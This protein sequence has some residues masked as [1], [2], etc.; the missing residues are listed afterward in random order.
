MNVESGTEAAQFPENTLMGFSLQ[1]ILLKRTV[2]G[3]YAFAVFNLGSPVHVP[4]GTGPLI[5]IRIE[6]CSQI[7]SSLLG[8]KVDYYIGLLYQ[9]ASI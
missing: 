6:P 8:D 4:G 5:I 2:S 3:C 9:P 1:C 7:H